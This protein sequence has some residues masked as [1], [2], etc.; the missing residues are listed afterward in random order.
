MLI[1]F[2]KEKPF[3]PVF[4]ISFIIAAGLSIACWDINFWPTDAEDY[5]MPAAKEL[6]SLSY[7]SQIH[8][9]L[10]QERIKWLHGK[11]YH[12][13]AISLFQRLMGDVHTLRPLVMLGIVC[14]FCSSL[15]VFAIS[16]RLW[17]D[18]LGALIWVFFTASFW[19]YLYILFAKHQTQG[20]CFFLLSVFCIVYARGWIFY[21][22][23][24]MAMAVS[25]FSSTVST[26]Y[27]LFVL[28]AL[29][30]GRK[31]LL[32]N[33]FLFF[34]GFLVPVIYA[35]YPNVME[36]LQSYWEYVRI[37][38]NS[39]HFF[40][41]Q[42]VL[43]QWLPTF[44][45]RDTRG[46]W[47]WILKY[48]ML[49]M[50]VIFPLYI[51]GIVYL[52]KKAFNWKTILLIALSFSPAV[53]A[54]IKGVAQY[55]ANYFPV[56]AGILMFLGYTVSLL[57]QDPLWPRV[58]K[59]IY[60]AAMMHLLWNGYVFALDIYP[61]RMATSLIS[62]FI[63]AKGIKE[64]HTFSAHPLRRNIVDH[65]NPAVFSSLKFTP[66]ESV[67]QVWSGYILLP[68]V[69]TDTIYRGSNGDYTDFD[70]DLVL[71]QILRQG[72]LGEYADASFKTL[73]SSLI[74]SQEEE[75][76]AY[77]NLILGQFKGGDA[78]RAWLL[79]AARIQKD[80]PLFLPTQEDLFLYRE[81]VG[82]IG[83]YSR[84]VMYAG[85]Q[86]AM[87]VASRLKG[88][89][90]R[91]FKMG[92]PNDHLRAFIFKVDDRQPMWVPYAS[93][94]ISQ[95]VP[96]SMISADPAGAPVVFTFDPPLDMHEGMFSIIIYRDGTPSD[97]DFYRIYADILGHV[98]E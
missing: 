68:P 79:D 49:V 14:I 95:P 59:F 35:T 63:E 94:F 75:I 31:G 38:G 58:R 43:A 73:G 10:D 30:W 51:A 13:L 54:E 20:L 16:R 64:L 19:P 61:C 57:V 4:L 25:V 77:R 24:G 21:V 18:K 12:V 88:V 33:S 22:L 26:L 23:A 71:N 90:V 89:A 11:E 27:F 65:L 46:G 15:L 44:D 5:Y 80:M 41:N 91:M 76:L 32:K 3:L 98:Q 2:L 52:L 83:T 72:K 93:N 40:Y 8:K 69:S 81:H 55:G 82:N 6:P 28:A 50:P 60:A 9:S 96:A 66:I 7:L 34:L 67:A 37:S 56:M 45:M 36:N 48:F 86:G 74:W 62:R 70:E 1:P 17:G 92:D 53:L 84:R 47:W 87:A 85:Y 97:V 78:S 42:R 29:L 39:N